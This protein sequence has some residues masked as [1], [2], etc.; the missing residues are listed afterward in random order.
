[1][2]FKNVNR[3]TVCS[4]ACLC[5]MLGLSGCQAYKAFKSPDLKPLVIQTVDVKLALQSSEAAK[6]EVTLLINNPN[7][8]PLPLVNSEFVLDV[9]GHGKCVTQYVLHRTV[10]ANGTQTVTVPVVI[11][12]REQVTATTGY[13]VKGVVSYVPPGEFRKLMTESKV[14][15]PVVMFEAEGQF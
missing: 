13:V 15:L 1:M 2:K 11:V 3:V 7:N 14:P 8:T 6:F 5:L 12:T 10:P 4:L 9:S